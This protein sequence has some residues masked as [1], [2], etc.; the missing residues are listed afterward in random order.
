MAFPTSAPTP[1]VRAI[2]KAPQNATRMV[3]RKIAAPPAFAPNAP[4]AARKIN[5][6]TDT[7]ATSWLG[8]ASVAAMIGSK[9]PVSALLS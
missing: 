5:D 9:A 2:A 7:I 8:E 4:S 3:G 6:V 1:A